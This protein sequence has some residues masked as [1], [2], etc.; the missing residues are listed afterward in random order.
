[1]HHS[2]P[3]PLMDHRK[4]HG[5]RRRRE[6]SPRACGELR[7]PR[8]NSEPQ[9]STTSVSSRSSRR[10]AKFSE[11]EGKSGEKFVKKKAKEPGGLQY[12]NN[13]RRSSTEELFVDLIRMP[14]LTSASVMLAFVV[15]FVVVFW[16]SYTLIPGNHFVFSE[17]V[18]KG[19]V[20]SLDVLFYSLSITTAYESPIRPNSKVT[21]LIGNIQALMVQVLMV[22]LTGVVFTR[23]TQSQPDI[24]AASV[25][26]LSSFNGRKCLM[27]RYV[28]NNPQEV[29]VDVRM[30]LTYKRH[31]ELQNG[32]RFFKYDT[33]SLMRSEAVR[34]KVSQTIVHF[35]DNDS[36]LYNKS[37][38]DLKAE[39]AVIDL[40]IFASEA[41]SMQPVFFVQ[42]YSAVKGEIQANKTYKDMIYTNT[43]GIRVIDHA[44]I[45]LLE[46]LQDIK[47][48]SS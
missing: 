46:D 47:D 25:A 13:I 7:S 14:T 30:G 41:F 16:M 28:F 5:L 4:K 31:V 44:N 19:T 8:W 21:L 24:T 9:G 29:F 6:S 20:G 43:E 36:P 15:V 39:K 48:A 26:I 27:A 10:P 32:S 23:L 17:D 2:Q 38:E 35:I 33:L 45:N 3:H 34:V 37:L 40:S 12:I 11:I 22:F 1:M 18:G 42:S